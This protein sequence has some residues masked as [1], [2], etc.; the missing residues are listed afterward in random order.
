MKF[1]TQ[2]TC[3][4]LT[5]ILSVCLLITPALAQLEMDAL[6]GLWLFDEGS[7]DTAADSSSSGLDAELVGSPKWVSGVFGSGLELDGSGAYVEVPAHVNPT[8]AITVSIWVKSM[9]ADWNQHGWM[10]EKRNA[11]IIH[12]NQGTKN[13]SWPICNGG[14]WN[15]PGNWRDGEVGPADI[16]DWHLY[17]ATFDSASGEWNIYIDG[18]AESTMEIDTNPIDADDGP[19]FIGR[20]TCCDGRFGDAVIDEVAIFNVALGEDDIQMMMEKGLSALLLTPV[21]PEGKLSTTWANVKQ[22]Y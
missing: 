19:V 15:K 8:D 11:Y 21:E 14:C 13:V 17:T 4:G 12:P 20:D 9:T 3:V 2:L 6:V 16:T 1:I 10:V 7:G 18:V 5:L 22:Q